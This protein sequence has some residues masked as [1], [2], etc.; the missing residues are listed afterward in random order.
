MLAIIPE[1]E[2]HNQ[3]PR[4][5]AD[6]YRQ[7]HGLSR[8]CQIIKQ[9]NSNQ[10]IPIVPFKRYPWNPT[11]IYYPRKRNP[12]ECKITMV[13]K[14]NN[15]ERIFKL[16]ITDNTNVNTPAL[17]LYGVHC[18]AARC[19]LLVPTFVYWFPGWT[20]SL[21]LTGYRMFRIMRHFFI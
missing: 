11:R 16:Y 9:I 6:R 2:N 5:S 3:W 1:E 19:R 21:W 14:I 18:T 15:D 13:T 7:E 4:H 10:E 20:F 17:P 8:F 12:S